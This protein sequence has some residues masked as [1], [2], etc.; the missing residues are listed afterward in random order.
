MAA[1]SGERESC[2]L[3]FMLREPVLSILFYRAFDPFQLSE[4]KLF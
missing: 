1:M 2:N 4:P 3:V